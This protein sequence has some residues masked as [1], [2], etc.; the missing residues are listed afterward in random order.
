MYIE[1]ECNGQYFAMVFERLKS[2]QIVD[3]PSSH[4]K[5]EMRAL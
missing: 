2:V 5:E 4:I 1:R 3:L